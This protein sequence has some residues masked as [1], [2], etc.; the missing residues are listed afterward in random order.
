[1]PEILDF[2]LSN[3]LFQARYAN[4]CR[5]AQISMCFHLGFDFDE[6][7]VSQPLGTAKLFI[8]EITSV[9]TPSKSTLPL[10]RGEG[11]Q[12]LPVDVQTR[13]LRKTLPLSG[14][15]AGI[16]SLIK[17][18]AFFLAPITSGRESSP[19][20]K[21]EDIGRRRGDIYESDGKIRKDSGNPFLV[22][23]EY[24]EVEE[25]RN[26]A[27]CYC[28]HPLLTIGEY[29]GCWKKLGRCHHHLWMGRMRAR[30]YVRSLPPQLRVQ[31]ER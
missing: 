7:G 2:V 28:Y 20:I 24:N 5:V 11:A 23:P 6:A 27:Q 15:P 9:P 21:W 1:M 31:V 13:V 22:L 14:L 10:R 19:N 4:C 25:A 26:N 12:F 18:E 29:R 16:T 3:T 17:V 30:K 8:H